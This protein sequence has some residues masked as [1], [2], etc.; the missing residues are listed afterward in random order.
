MLK[1]KQ[2]FLFFISFL[3]L[4]S[5]EKSKFT[6]TNV[7]ST[8]PSFIPPDTIDSRIVVSFDSLREVYKDDEFHLWGSYL[9]KYDNRQLLAFLTSVYDG[10]NVHDKNI[11]RSTCLSIAKKNEEEKDVQQKVVEQLLEVEDLDLFSK[12]LLTFQREDF[13][14]IAKGMLAKMKIGEKRREILL[15]GLA[16]IEERR[17]HLERI[18]GEYP[19][20]IE[21]NYWYKKPAWYA[22]LALIR[23]GDTEY[24]PYCLEV[25]EKETNPI[26]LSYFMMDLAYMRHPKSIQL[27]ADY[28]FSD[29]EKT[30]DGDAMGFK[31]GV[32]ALEQLLNIAENP[33]PTISAYHGDLD[34]GKAWIK[35]SEQIR[36]KN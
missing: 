23:M 26:I 25:I 4:I 18:V 11:I 36:I 13:S 29:I 30:G 12:S 21:R 17:D 28:V 7:D 1:S 10:S 6:I 14:P 31:V 3:C 22:R 27:L 34:K 8:I 9:L 32:R 5:C 35:S 33:P 15:V 19:L 24:L 16:N 2:Y 20:Y